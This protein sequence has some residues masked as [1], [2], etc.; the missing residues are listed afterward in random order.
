VAF[1]N[2]EL[3]YPSINQPCNLGGDMTKK[4]YQLTEKGKKLLEKLNSSINMQDFAA[5][6]LGLEPM[7]GKNE[8]RSKRNKI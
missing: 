3:N 1:D 2:H 7:K 6:L 4:Q 5:E 8:R